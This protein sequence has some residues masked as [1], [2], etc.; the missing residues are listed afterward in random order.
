MRVVPT[1]EFYPSVCACTNRGDGPFVDFESTLNHI[2]A[3]VY[4]RTDIVQ[5]AAR[6]LGMVDEADLTRAREEAS[7]ARDDV[8]ALQEELDE[9]RRALD[10]VHVLESAAAFKARKKPGPKK[11]VAA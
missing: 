5:S 8:K 11:K 10:A 1:A 2:D 7:L 3:H 6:L 9:A 4:L